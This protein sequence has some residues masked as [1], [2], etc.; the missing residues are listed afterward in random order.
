MWCRR[1]RS[2]PRRR[3]ATRASPGRRWRA[4]G[5]GTR[6]RPAPRPPRGG[7]RPRRT[8]ARG[9]PVSR[10]SASRYGVSIDAVKFSATPSCITFTALAWNRPP[11]RARRRSTRSATCSTPRSRSHQSAPTT[12]ERRSPFAAARR[13]GRAGVVHA[14]VRADDRVLPGRDADGVQ[15][16]LAL[17]QP[18]VVL[19]GADP[20]RQPR[21]QRH[22][23]LVQG[24]GRMPVGVAL[25][26]PVGGV[27]GVPVDAGELQ[28]AG[29]DP[30]AVV[31]AVRQERRP[32][33]DDRVEVGGGRRP[34]RERR[35]RPAAAQ[36]PLELGAPRRRTP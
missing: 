20:R 1:P 25:D 12:C 9:W 18:A 6:P 21:D 16:A 13:V 29:V 22:R 7:R 30:G 2:C 35:H 8:S 27:R 28:G 15:V 32:V 34:T 26:P 24:A 14:G 10:P 4:R 36:D 3:P 23:A 33:R 17:Q 19:L 11:L 31:V 5:P